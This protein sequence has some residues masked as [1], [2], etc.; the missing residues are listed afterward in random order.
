MNVVR[1]TFELDSETD[2]RLQAI[3]A[4]R[5]QGVASVVADAIALLDAVVP[6][7]GPDIEEDIRRIREYERTGQAVPLE[8]V[9]AWVESWDSANELPRPKPRKIT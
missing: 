9:K 6:L 8:D 4:A 1:R 5:G 2:A 7:E 3:A